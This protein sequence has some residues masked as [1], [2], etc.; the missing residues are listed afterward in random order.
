M[1]IAPDQ[2]TVISGLT[3]ITVIAD[4][5]VKE[6]KVVKLCHFIDDFH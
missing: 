3:A 4:I 6:N 2:Q 5:Y 1:L